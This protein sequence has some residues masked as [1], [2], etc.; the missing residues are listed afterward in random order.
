MDRR[1]RTTPGV[2]TVKF[3]CNS[4]PCHAFLPENDF[5]EVFVCCYQEFIVN[6][7]TVENLFVAC[8]AIKFGD[9][10]NG[11]A[12]GTQKFDDGAIDVFVSDEV[13]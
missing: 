6:V 10:S 7:G 8:A 1:I 13:H 12:V 4:S 2:M 9:V 5:T 11:V 3:P